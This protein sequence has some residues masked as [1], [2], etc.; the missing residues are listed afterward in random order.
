MTTRTLNLRRRGAV[1]VLDDSA[2][3]ASLRPGR[4]MR[5]AEIC[6]DGRTVEVRVN[7]HRPSGVSIDGLLRLD[8][9]GSRVAPEGEPVGWTMGRERGCYA[10]SVVRGEDRIDLRLPRRGGPRVEIVLTGTWPDLELVALAASFALLAR[11]RAARLRAMAV[12]GAMG[13]GPVT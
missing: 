2:A 9:R 11:R 4:R 1:F 7:D 6:V 3:A 12:A 5:S 8:P 13:H 10:A